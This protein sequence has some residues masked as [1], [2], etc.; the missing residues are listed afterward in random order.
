MGKNEPNVTVHIT[1]KVDAFATFE[2][3]R[4]AARTPKRP[5]RRRGSMVGPR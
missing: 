4:L 3:G 5:R 1:E 2:E